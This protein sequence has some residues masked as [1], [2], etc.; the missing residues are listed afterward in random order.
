MLADAAVVG[1]VFWA[2]AVAE[3]GGHT[4]AEVNE[5]M[6]ELSRKEL[7]RPERLSTMEGESE[8]AFWHVLARDVAYAELPRAARAS[9]HVAAA[10]W[11][12]SKAPERVED[13]ADVLAYHYATALEL[14]RAAGQTALA[15]ELEA[16]AHRFLMLSGERALGLDTAAALDDFE[17][18]LALT[19]S[20]HPSRAESLARFG[21]AAYQAARYE[22]AAG[23]L[24]E[25]TA[26]FRDRGESL[27][28]ARAMTDLAGALGFLNDPRCPELRLEVLSLLE[29]LPPGRELV[30]ALWYLAGENALLYGRLEEAA[31]LANRSLSVAA[32]LGLPRPAL[33]L[34]VRADARYLLG[35]PGGLEDFREALELATQAGDGNQSAVLYNNFGITL[36]NL[37]GPGAALEAFEEG[38][39]L[40]EACGLKGTALNIQ[41]S[42]LPAMLGAGELGRAL[43]LAENLGEHAEEA[44]DEFDLMEIRSVQTIALV[45]QGRASEALGFLDQMVAAARRSGRPDLLTTDLG[46][47]AVARAEL[48][49]A[50]A[51]SALLA[52]IEATPDLDKVYELA[53]YLPMI[54]RTALKVGEPGLAERIVGRLLPRSP[55]DE[56]TL[57][58]VSAALTEARGEIDTAARAYA[59]A[60][61]RWERFGVVPEQGFALLG[62]GRCLL[63]LARAGESADVLRRAGG[64]FT[65]CGMHPAL[66]ETDALL[67]SA[68]ALP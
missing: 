41:T 38:R 46:C 60:A 8:Y 31:G 27:A 22:D 23:A 6:R 48:G 2:G 49:E 57:A 53:V 29:P 30:D 63:E 45:L 10:R 36:R 68:T 17:R 15:S 52:E 13:L 3:M 44:G 42:A 12:E 33:A 40:A 34:G 5:A 67:A 4:E 62:W 28:A 61:E 21:R 59:D 55:Y 32:E 11:I 1:K 19:P 14:A 54:V 43:E 26:I 9:R 65:G 37:E 18:A 47:V 24:E 64:I 25:A 56:H 58:A 7:V 35:D 16:P 66:E 20:G 51:S 39:S 50:E